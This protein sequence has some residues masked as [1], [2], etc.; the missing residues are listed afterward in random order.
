MPFRKLTIELLL[1]DPEG[2]EAVDEGRLVGDIVNDLEP[3][4]VIFIESRTQTA[5]IAVRARE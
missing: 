2:G 1:I 3:T 4:E 5:K